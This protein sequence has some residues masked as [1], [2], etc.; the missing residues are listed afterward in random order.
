[1]CFCRLVR[2]MYM[3]G[4]GRGLMVLQGWCIGTERHTARLA[5]RHFKS[6]TIIESCFDISEESDGHSFR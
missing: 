6:D 2:N 1:M 3:N 5:M 4:S